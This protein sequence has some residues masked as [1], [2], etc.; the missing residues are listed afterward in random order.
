MH[1][2]SLVLF[3]AAAFGIVIAALHVAAVWRRPAPA[4]AR[5]RA[6]PPISILK[7]LC[8]VDDDLEA[9]LELFATALDYPRYE[10]VLG[11]RSVSD[12]AWPLAKALAARHPGR[13]RAVV[14]RGEPGLNPKVN[15]LI[16]LAAAARFDLLVVSDSNVQ[17]GPGYLSEIASLFESADV[18][19]VTHPTVGVGER[20]F[21]ALLDNLHMISTGSSMIAAKDFAGQDIVVGKSM[22]FRRVDLEAL[23]G[24]QSVK[25]VL[26][27]DYLLGRWVSKALGRRVVV[28]LE[29]VFNVTRRRTV[30]EFLR[31]FSRWSVMQRQAVGT[32]TY[33]AQ[34]LL[35]PSALALLGFAL[36]PEPR[37]ALALLCCIGAKSACDLAVAT[38]LRPTRL[39]P[40]A[41]LAAPLRELGIA[42][43]WLH[44]LLSNHVDWRGNRLRVLPGTRL[45]LPEPETA[46][47]TQ[48]TEGEAA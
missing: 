2:L 37:T 36:D 23:G 27:E 15:Q 33:L 42:A 22:A 18:G 10:V 26:A 24:F 9:N 45:A 43:A 31:R 13:V 44:G 30:L 47:A 34:A 38:R 25:D 8:G 20:S 32:P 28:G 6:A 35:T 14:Q 3:A 46:L 11:V 41:F 7:P 29:P 16:T 40:L 4:R 17:V 48:R 39:P 1:A 21:G 19:L 5:P 12:A